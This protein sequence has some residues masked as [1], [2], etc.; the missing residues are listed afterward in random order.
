MPSRGS[1]NQ[2]RSFSIFVC[3]HMDRR[4]GDSQY[5]MCSK[6]WDPQ[7]HLSKGWSKHIIFSL[8]HLVIHKRIPR[9]QRLGSIHLYSW[10]TSC[11]CHC[12]NI[13]HPL[14]PKVFELLRLRA[15]HQHKRSLRCTLL[16]RLSR[17]IQS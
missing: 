17:C 7:D 4:A 11:C 2:I 6:M 13:T 12:V 14:H 1:E 9:H 5:Q 3:S 16:Q 8:K 10:K 15:S